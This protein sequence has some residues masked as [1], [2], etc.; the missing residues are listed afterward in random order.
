M[1][2]NLRVVQWSTGGCGAIAVRTLAEREGI[3]L[4]GV[5]VHAPDKQG[6]DAGELIG[7]PAMGL[8]T[9]GDADAL[10]ALA[11]DCISYTASGESR[12]KEC[13]E[14]Y[15]RLLGHGIN[16]VTTSVPGLVHPAGFDPSAVAAIQDACAS[17]KASLYASGMEPG[18]AGDH[19]VLALTTLSNRID[20]IRTQEVFG[21]ED[22]PV[23][24]TIYDVFGFGKPEG[25]RCIM[26]LPGVQASAWAPPV[27]MVADHLGAKL[28]TIKETYQKRITERTLEVAAGTIEAG[29]VGA[30]R[31]ETIGVIHGKD[32]IVIEHINR[33]APDIAPDWPSASRD[34]TYRVMVEGD[35]SFACELTLGSEAD[36]TDHGMVGTT[37]RIVNAIPAVCAAPPGIVTAADLPLTL[38]P[39]PFRC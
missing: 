27:R 17:G 19:L 20:T 24:F 25:H 14:D 9:T 21:Y 5:W 4:V 23:P 16:I 7:A 36:Y 6:R 30:V 10:I 38:P 18:F 8:E 1:T 2:K 26:E 3:D 31:F 35:P 28:D 15:C 37:M 13:I 33:L 34:G 11:P 32:A 29:T 39:N 22:Y 12:P